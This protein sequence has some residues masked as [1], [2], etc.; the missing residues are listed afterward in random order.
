M[1]WLLWTIG[2]SKNIPLTIEWINSMMRDM[3]NA[4]YRIL[5]LEERFG[6]FTARLLREKVLPELEKLIEQNKSPN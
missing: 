5:T 6:T 1:N 3:M 2:E 4:P